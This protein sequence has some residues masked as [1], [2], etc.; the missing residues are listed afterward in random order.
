LR[1]TAHA[2]FSGSPAVPRGGRMKS[3]C[4]GQRASLKQ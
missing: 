4:C 3:T 2:G 1:G